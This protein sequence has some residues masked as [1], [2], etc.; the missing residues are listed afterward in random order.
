VRGINNEVD[1]R[2]APFCLRSPLRK[3]GSRKHLDTR[4][5]GYD[6]D[7]VDT[8][9]RGYDWMEGFPPSRV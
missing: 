7:G 9:L 1:R 6:E 5:R 8:R 3:Q 2:V 4:L